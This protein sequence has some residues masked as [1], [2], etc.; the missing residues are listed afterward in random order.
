MFVQLFVEDGFT[1]LYIACLFGKVAVISLLLKAGADIEAKDK[2]S[3]FLWLVDVIA[4]SRMER[5]LFTEPVYGGM[6][7]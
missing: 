2:V 7:L 3:H 5:Y 4:L 6:W 1:P